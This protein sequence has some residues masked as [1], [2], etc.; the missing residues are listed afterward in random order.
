LPDVNWYYNIILMELLL[1]QIRYLDLRQPLNYLEIEGYPSI[2][3]ENDDFLLCYELNPEQSRS[4]EPER[5]KLITGIVFAGKKEVSG[6]I[7]LPAGHYIF[8][9]YRRDKPLNNDEWFDMAIE[10]Q[11]DGLWERNKLGNL[12]FIRFFYEDGMFVTQI[13]RTI[14]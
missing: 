1:T 2:I 7:L 8:S 3:S 5:D 10:Q 9:Q 4:I 14:E 12:L 6:T 13:F 11:K